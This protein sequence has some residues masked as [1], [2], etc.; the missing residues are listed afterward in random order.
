MRHAT[1]IQIV[2]HFFLFLQ[3]LLKN[4]GEEGKALTVIVSQNIKVAVSKTKF[5]GEL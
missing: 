1:R 2:L 3:M 5:G 4:R